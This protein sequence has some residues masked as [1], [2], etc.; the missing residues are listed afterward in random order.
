MTPLCE[1]ST[2]RRISSDFERA[3]QEST[4]RRIGPNF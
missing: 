2:N 3:M 4:D 1:G